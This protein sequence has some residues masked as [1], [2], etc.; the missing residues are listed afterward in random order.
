MRE[1]TVKLLDTASCW[2]ADQ[3]V[4]PRL[5]IGSGRS[6]VRFSLLG[7]FRLPDAFARLRW[8]HPSVQPAS[9]WDIAAAVCEPV[10][11]FTS[12]RRAIAVSRSARTSI[13]P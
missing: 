8:R 9:F 11:N 5:S 10:K 13:R 2:P 3:L 12:Q 4:A 1:L 6:L 7:F